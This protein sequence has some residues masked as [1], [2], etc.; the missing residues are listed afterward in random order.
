M[1]DKTWLIKD[2]NRITGPFNEKE[3]QT[4]LEKGH[5]SPFATASQPGQTFWGFLVVYPEFASYMDSTTLTQLTKT[6][7]LYNFTKTQDTALNPQAPSHKKETPAPPEGQSLPYQVITQKTEEKPQ[8]RKFQLA[9]ITGSFL[10]MFF[11]IGLFFFN[12]EKADQDT[13]PPLDQGEA[14][15]SAG[16]YKKALAIWTNKAPKA[17]PQTLSFKIL[18][19]Q[20]ENDIS[21]T[22]FLMKNIK[23]GDRQQLVQALVQLKTEDLS[24][25]RQGLSQLMKKSPSKEIKQVAFANLALLSAREKQCDFFKTRQEKFFETED[26]IHFL[27]SFCLLSSNGAENRQ[28]AK[29][30]LMEITKKKESYYQESLLGLIYIQHEEGQVETDLIQSLLDSDPYAGDQDHY[31]VWIDRAIYSWPHML[32]LCEKLYSAK[33][34]GELFVSLYAYCLTRAGRHEQALH[35]IKKAE[36]MDPENALVKSIHAYIMDRINMKNDSALI[37]GKALKINAEEQ[38]VLPDILQAYFCSQKENWFCAVQHWQKVL[39]QHPDSLFSLGNM[40]YA[41]YRQ[42]HLEEA[43]EYM[44]LSLNLSPNTRNSPLLFVQQNLKE[45][46]QQEPA[47]EEKQQDR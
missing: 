2:Q 15:F 36:S 5:I 16:H 21:V 45:L 10:A 39:K 31:N 38:Y 42:G 7:S 43:K 41:K 11:A 6:I 3:I 17:L 34:H 30:M 26:L 33:E 20:L 29:T 18:K 9:I 12:E 14:W 13:P 40:V 8:S 47:Q 19:F 37:L 25:A 22:D 44:K 23:E 24:V 35:K 27:F 1:S 32:P 4:Q 46:A 28:K